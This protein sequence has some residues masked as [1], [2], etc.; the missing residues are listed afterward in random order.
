MDKQRLVHYSFLI[1][2]VSKGINAATEIVGGILLFF[3]SAGSVARI[4]VSLTAG[5]LSEDPRDLVAN[6][7]LKT[8]NGLSVDKLH[9]A[10]VY[11]IV[12]GVVK[13]FLVVALLKNKLWAFPAAMAVFSVFII[14]Q[15]YRYSLS[16]SNWLLALSFFDL[17]VIALTWFEYRR[18]MMRTRNKN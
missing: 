2:I 4:V 16:F 7:L 8:A 13:I 18:I 6:F 10:G 11:L 9:F 5:E 15:L 17:L 12:H 3:L 14:Y 1:G